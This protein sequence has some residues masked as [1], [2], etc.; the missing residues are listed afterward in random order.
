[1]AKSRN[2]WLLDADSLKTYG[3]C[4]FGWLVS[5]WNL[6]DFEFSW[7]SRSSMYLC[8]F[9]QFVSCISTNHL[10]FY[11]LG[12]ICRGFGTHQSAESTAKKSGWKWP[13][14]P[15]C[16]WHHR[17]AGFFS[18]HQQWSNL[19]SLI[20]F[21][22]ETMRGWFSMEEETRHFLGNFLP[23]NNFLIYVT[24]RP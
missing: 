1:M 17:S 22:K 21:W 20:C 3:I 12:N 18:S 8:Q 24:S 11:A 5:K 15:Q 19:N 2:H 4:I 10:A 16:L 23:D 6:E 14:V 7:N 13:A 9:T